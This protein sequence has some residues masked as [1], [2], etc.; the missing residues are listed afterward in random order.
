MSMTTCSPSTTC[1]CALAA[2]R[3][4]DP[5]N[6][7]RFRRSLDAYERLG[8]GDN[9]KVT[10]EV[11]RRLIEGVLAFAA[12]DYARA[13]E[14]ILP[15]RYEAVRIGGKPRAARHCQPD[16]DRG[17]RTL[18]P[19]APG[20][21]AARRARRT[22]GR[23]GAESEVSFGLALRAASRLDLFR[24]YGPGRAFGGLG[25]LLTSLISRQEVAFSMG[26]AALSHG[27]AA[28]TER[29]T[30]ARG[31]PCGQATTWLIE[32]ILAA[33]DFRGRCTLPHRSGPNCP[34]G[35]FCS[36]ESPYQTIATGV[37]GDADRRRGRGDR[38]ETDQHQGPGRRPGNVGHRDAVQMANGGSWPRRPCR[39]E[40]QLR[41]LS[42]AV[43][44]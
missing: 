10:A 41:L 42:F 35:R 29:R 13:V 30:G 8:S 6:V 18:G 21:R 12:A 5:G 1:H 37:S 27:G 14:A 33:L 22:F 43:A 39:C 3:S 16:P 24:P 38:K 25:R 44:V 17:G 31:V 23:R 11:G 7:E 2:A 20:A 36:I 19:M 34:G 28:R 26:Y 15:V 32:A 4:T 9:M 40:R